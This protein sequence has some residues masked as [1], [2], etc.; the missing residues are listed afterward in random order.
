[1]N[2]FGIPKKTNY[3]AWTTSTKIGVFSKCESL[4]VQSSS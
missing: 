3:N 4:A 1:M 2:T